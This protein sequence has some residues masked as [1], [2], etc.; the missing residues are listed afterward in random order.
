MTSWRSRGGSSL[1]RTAAVNFV[2]DGIKVE[3][4]R[5]DTI[6]SALLANDVSIVGRSFKYHRPRGVWG[7]GVEEPNAIVDIDGVHYRPNS[8]A[9]T[10]F[11][12]EGLAVRSVNNR[13][14]A[15]DDRNAF[16]DRFARFIPAAFYYKTFMFPDWHMFEPRIREMAGLGS[17]RPAGGVAD[18]SDQINQH[19]D[20]LVVGGGPAGVA[21][22]LAAAQDGKKVVLCEQSER[23]GGSLL[24]TA[25]TVNGG[26]GIDW[27]AN[28]I[29]RLKMLGAVILTDTT[30]FGVYDHLLVALNERLSDGSSRLWRVRPAQLVLATGALERPLPFANNDLPGVMSC[31]AALAYLRKF[32]VVAG[33]DVV[34]ATNNSSAYEAARALSEAGAKVTLVDYRPDETPRRSDFAVIQG[35]TVSAARGKNRVEAIELSDGTRL[36]ADSVLVSG[37]YSPT[38]HL[39]CQAQGKLAWSDE[40]LA[41]IPGDPVRGVM[42]AGSAAGAFSPDQLT[43]SIRESLLALGHPSCEV[44]MFL[45]ADFDGRSAIAA[46][47]RP[48]SKGRVWIDLQNDVTAKDVEL[49]ARENFISVEHLK[50]YS[51]LGMATDQGKTSNL[52]GLALMAEV[53]G[54]RIPEVG[55]TTYRPPFTPV[56][57]Q[58]L[59]GHRAK[60]RMNPLRR[61]PLEAAHRQDGAVFREYGGWLRPAFYGDGAQANEVHREV[62][63]ARR[64]AALF[65]GSPLGKIEVM[66]PQA[67]EFLDF[68]YY[69]TVSSLKPGRCRYGFI[70]AE[71]GI[72]YDDGVLMRLD[73]NRFI[74]SCSSSHVA[75]MYALLEEWRQ[76]RFDRRRL[77]IHNASAESA[78]LTVSGPNSRA[79]LQKAGI[80]VELGDDALPHMAATTG[81]LSGTRVR[82]T[83]VS[84]T[85]DRS[86]EVSVPALDAPR[87]W[88]LLKQAGTAFDASLLGM[89]ALMV[90]RAEKGYIIVG[91]DTDG[92]SRPMDFGLTA[93][94]EKKKV[95]FIGRRSLLA[96]EAQRPDRQQFVGLEVVDGGP[97]FATGAHGVER[98]D[99]KTRSLGYV[100]SSYL[101]PTLGR[102]IA[103]GLIESGSSRH[104]DIIEVQHLG[105][106]RKARIT[107]PC[108]FDPEGARLNA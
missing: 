56:S 47:P 60:E 63:S 2:F 81:T 93:P 39:F 36:R 97:P 29:M 27:L 1:D 49:A 57:F 7:A 11:V 99:G 64:S 26:P 58:S 83:R 16:I 107:V 76:D 86:Y 13:P 95:E 12:E 15:R 96:K 35:Q 28:S 54:R 53:T 87:L 22:A 98:R 84:F 55:T 62:T 94:L 69:N 44:P 6:A 67:A 50:R 70:L 85:G 20:L 106:I 108:A 61:L 78:T 101:S 48:K 88:G 4:F 17:L 30:A 42:V 73:D 43:S 25:I 32:G 5:G 90:M 89:E 79:L 66:G 92:M 23:L 9:T 59:A 41:F 51:T 37:G 45:S 24:H 75:G 71:S 102:P 33:R 3:A 38:V 21:T 8:R 100:T 19:C 10:E 77:F 74:V 104:G 65:D 18:E 46:W 31:D 72:V 80:D 68:V 91:K 105:A 34:V 14:S 40:K 103:L 82:V 52:N